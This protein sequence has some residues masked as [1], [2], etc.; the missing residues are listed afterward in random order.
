MDHFQLEILNLLT[1]SDHLAS[2]SQ[3]DNQPNPP[4]PSPPTLLC[5][6]PPVTLFCIKVTIFFFHSS[7]QTSRSDSPTTSCC[8]WSA[9]GTLNSLPG[10][11]VSSFYSLTYSKAQLC[12]NPLLF[13][14]SQR[15]LTPPGL[16]TE[17]G[18]YSFLFQQLVYH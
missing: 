13:L 7:L 14:T 1:S 5:R 2:L 6:F 17:N 3:T 10:S 9:S 15:V 4:P 8:W 16:V 12:E 11:L 18:D